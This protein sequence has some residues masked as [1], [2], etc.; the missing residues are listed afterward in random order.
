MFKGLL[1]WLTVRE[2]VQDECHRL[3]NQGRFLEVVSILESQKARAGLDAECTELLVRALCSQHA[4]DRGLSLVQHARQE[5]PSDATLYLLEGICLEGIANGEAALVAYARALAL[6]AALPE[7][8]ARS[9]HL[10][11]Q[12]HRAAEAIDLA[13]LALRTHP[14]SVDLLFCRANVL[15]ALDRLDE[16]C[17]GFEGILEA[18]PQHVHALANLAAI[19]MQRADAAKAE[20]FLLRALAVEPADFNLRLQ[21]ARCQQT[22]GN[23]EGA[24]I[25]LRALQDERP[26]VS[27]VHRLMGEAHAT[28][29]ELQEAAGCFAQAAL[30][31]VGSFLP[32]LQLGKV[33]FEIGNYDQAVKALGKSLK[34]RVTAEAHRTSGI[35]LLRGFRVQDAVEHLEAALELEPDNADSKMLLS[36]ARG[37]LQEGSRGASDEYRRILATDPS[38][39]F[40]HS[41]LLFNLS[42]D[43]SCSPEEYLEETRR[44]GRQLQK[45]LARTVAELSARRQGAGHPI[46]IGMVSGDL[47]MHPVGYFLLGL[48]QNL[49]RQRFAPYL[50]SSSFKEDSLSLKLKSLSASWRNLRFSDDAE[51]ARQIAGDGIDILFDLSGHTGKNRLGIFAIR[52]APVQVS[53]LGYW[54]STGVENMDCILADP[55]CVPV[56]EERFF[57][58][59]VIRMPVTRLCFGESLA[60]APK[61]APSPWASNGFITFGCFQSLHKVSADVLLAW[62]RILQ[63]NPTSRLLLRNMQFSDAGVR[64]TTQERFEAAGL[65]ADRLQLLPPL[66]REGYLLGYA[67]IDACLDTFPFPGGTTTCDAM[68]MGVPTISVRG[69]NMISRQG[70]AMLLAAGLGE[71]VVADTEAYVERAAELCRSAHTLPEL[72]KGMRAKVRSSALFDSQRFA[73][74][75]GEVIQTLADEARDRSSSVRSAPSSA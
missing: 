44:F 60:D 31:D 26:D 6:Q 75:F 70:E 10:L 24:L 16:A 47:H 57:T 59:R 54:A 72:R 11:C 30:L 35:A 53:W 4:H 27:E 39:H 34:I 51:A 37:V 71:W 62:S 9:C 58:E 25:T 52:A 46:R 29:Q 50:Y 49:D 64:K 32:Y 69:H 65:P 55:T 28:R 15:F 19:A 17:A 68:W 21:W 56:E 20:E 8:V 5:R 74:D 38:A 13:E 41:N 67:E 43:A 33:L 63:D 3:F 7:A 12:Q 45:D 61:A 14:G 42:F 23:S 66:S 18:D 73:R 40:V 2:S 36:L 1:T 22:S 48:L